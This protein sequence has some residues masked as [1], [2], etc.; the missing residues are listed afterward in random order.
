MPSNAVEQSVTL[1]LVASDRFD[2]IG[3]IA[4]CLAANC[5]A[6]L[7]P[8]NKAQVATEIATSTFP[9]FRVVPEPD[10]GPAV[11]VLIV[12]QFDVFPLHQLDKSVGLRLLGSLVCRR[13]FRVLR[14]VVTHCAPFPLTC[15]RDS[16]HLTI[17]ARFQRTALVETR[18]RRG[19]WPVRS[20]LQIVVR[21][22]PTRLLTSFW[23]RS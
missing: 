13:L 17:S 19:N 8:V 22:R 18:R 15:W 3:G 1:T 16:I 4:K 14:R 11:L 12:E 21:E 6:I 2:D 5:F 10:P 9:D 7:L 20:N 23:L